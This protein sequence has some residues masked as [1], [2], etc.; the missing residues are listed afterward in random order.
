[1]GQQAF[2][3][4]LIQAQLDERKAN[5]E[6]V[7]KLRA[8]MELPISTYMKP[9]MQSVPAPA[10]TPGTAMAPYAPGAMLE[11]QGKDVFTIPPDTPVRLAKQLMDIKKAMA[12]E[13]TKYQIGEPGKVLVGETPGQPPSF[14]TIPGIPTPKPPTNKMELTR[15]R[16]IE[17][18]KQGTATEVYER[19]QKESKGYDT[20]R[21]ALLESIEMVKAAGADAGLVPGYELTADNK[22]SPKPIPDITKRIPPFT[23][24]PGMIGIGYDRKKNKYIESATG[25]ELTK[26]E[27]LIE[28]GETSILG[29]N[30]SALTRLE[31]TYAISDVARRAAENHANTIKALAKKKNDTGIPALDRWFRAGKKAIAGDVDVTN[32]DIAIHHYDTELARYLSSMTSGGTLSEHE[33]ERYR[34]LIS[35]AMR[36]EQ[37]MGSLDTVS[38]LM[39]GKQKAFIDERESLI[40]RFTGRQLKQPG[41]GR[42][43]TVV[44]RGK[45]TSGSNMGKTVIEYSDGSREYVK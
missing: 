30:K 40:S 24:A 1:M 14:E 18:G 21:E 16:L 20:P 44:R 34:K 4:Q 26:E 12:P 2:Q 31:S 29:A 35:G 38:E 11:Q 17:E 39:T 32:L 19:M 36:S 7:T 22:Y 5:L 43:K 33:A 10:Y 6:E 15:Q 13:P 9:S 8:G 41:S 45:V 37:I 28:F 23:P 27:A 42:E 25:R 3:M